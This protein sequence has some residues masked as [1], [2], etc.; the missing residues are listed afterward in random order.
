V[1]VLKGTDKEKEKKE[2]TLLFFA[3]AF[4]QVLLAL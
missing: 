2:N 1:E 4:V 3:E